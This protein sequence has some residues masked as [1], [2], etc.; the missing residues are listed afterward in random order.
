[1]VYLIFYHCRRPYYQRSDDD[2]P[3]EHTEYLM[4]N[5]NPPDVYNNHTPLARIQRKSSDYSNWASDS[6]L[7]QSRISDDFV[8]RARSKTDADLDEP[9]SRDGHDGKQQRR[10]KRSFPLS[11]LRRLT[12][13]SSTKSTPGSPKTSKHHR[14]P[15]PNNVPEY[16]PLRRAKFKPEAKRKTSANI[17]RKRKTSYPLSLLRKQLGDVDGGSTHSVPDSFNSPK[18]KASR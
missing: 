16:V 4:Y 15:D 14:E 18:H 2:V 11:L 13:S 1:M 10:R 6:D 8:G 3:G 17:E 7:R 5:G 12:S 9:I